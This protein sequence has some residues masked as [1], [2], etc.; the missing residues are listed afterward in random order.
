[1]PLKSF[2]GNFSVLSKIN[3][4]T[5]SCQLELSHPWIL[6]ILLIPDIQP[7]GNSESPFKMFPESDHFLSC[8]PNT[9]VQAIFICS[10]DYCWSP[11]LQTQPIL[12]EKG[13]IL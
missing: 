4:E 1:M 12:T 13:L 2:L 7:T 11:C 8:V 3:K 9:L 5:P 6:S 10:L